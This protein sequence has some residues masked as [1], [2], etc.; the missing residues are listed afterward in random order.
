MSFTT[1]AT[2]LLIALPGRADLQGIVTSTDGEQISGALVVIDTAA[3]K[4]GTSSLCPSCYADCGRRAE[5]A[6]DGSF[7]IDRLDADLTFQVLVIAEGYRSKRVKSVDP[8]KGPIEVTLNRLDLDSLKPKCILRGVVL[9]PEGHPVVGASLEPESFKTDAYHGFA[10]DIVDPLV[11]TNRSG[12]FLMTSKSPISYVSLRVKG[13]GL[14]PRIF[15]KCLIE[16]SPH[17]LRMTRGVDVTGRIMLGRKPLDDVV[18]GLVQ[19]DRGMGHFLGAVQIGTD[20]KGRFLF[21]NVAPNQHYYIYG[22]MASFGDR[23]AIEARPIEVGADGST[24]DVGDVP[25][26]PAHKIAGTVLLSDK[27]PIPSGTRIMISREQAW[28][29]QE[30]VVDPDGKFVAAGLPTERYSV[31]VSL[32]G[33]QLSP[34]NKT[35]T[36][37][38]DQD[39][40]G[41]KILMEPG[42]RR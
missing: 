13:R 37:M 41:L 23:G 27:K 9:D 15:E 11:V 19:V 7:A 10:P 26:G 34:K 2:L 30:A 17:R 24:L 21:S 20:R 36:G 25:V 40:L 4:Q 38:V 39:I 29:H 14:A 18:V 12:E 32:K 22:I 5:T 28:D 16:E 6:A 3:V 35:L 42:E 31:Y 1:L 8:A 33:Y